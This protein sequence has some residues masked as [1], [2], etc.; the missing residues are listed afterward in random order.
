MNDRIK[1]HIM[2]ARQAASAPPASS[3]EDRHAQNVKTAVNGALHIFYDKKSHDKISKMIPEGDEAAGV[4]LVAASLIEAVDDHS[5]GNMPD[6]VILPAAMLVMQDIADF[7][8]QSRGVEF[9]DHMQKAATLALMHKLA[10]DYGTTP[11][12][13]Q[14]ALGQVDPSLLQEGQAVGDQMQQE[15]SGQQPQ[16]PQQPQQHAGL[17]SM[18]NQQQGA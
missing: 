7:I 1:Q 17:L 18:A 12:Q 14:E 2:G 6:D 11:E 8:T 4:A 5:G 13:M 3:E 10:K 15:I 9:D 16:Q